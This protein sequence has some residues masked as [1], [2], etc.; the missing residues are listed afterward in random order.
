[1][2]EGGILNEKFP[3]GVV[4][5]SARL[6]TEGHVIETKGKKVVVK[7]YTKALVET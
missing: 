2:K 4:N 5:Q 3:G 1:L 6:S 7:D